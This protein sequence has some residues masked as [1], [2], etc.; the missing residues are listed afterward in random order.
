MIEGFVELL[1]DY[2]PYFWVGLLVIKVPS[3]LKTYM[4]H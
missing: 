4:M 2:R 3:Y 1:G